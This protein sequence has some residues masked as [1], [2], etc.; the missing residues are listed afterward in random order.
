MTNQ[1]TKQ[2]EVLHG[3]GHIRRYFPATITVR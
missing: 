3:G 2:P 1:A